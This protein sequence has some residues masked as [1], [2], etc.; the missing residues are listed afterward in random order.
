MAVGLYSKSY[1]E[2]Y[3]E[4]PWCRIG[5]YIVGIVTGYLLAAQRD[6]I[7]LNWSIATIG[8]LA[9]TAVALAVIFGLHKDLENAGEHAMS[10]AEAAFYNALA[11]T[12]WAV[13]ICWV[14]VACATGWGGFVNSF[15]SWS[16]FVVLGRLSYL[17]YLIHVAVIDVYFGNQ[18]TLLYFT[19]LHFAMCFVGI[20]VV[21]YMFSFVLMLA[22]ESPMIGLEKVVLHQRTKI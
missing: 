21:T 7:K 2:N 5:P 1:F 12:A 17:A 4:A 19:S 15:L 20:I 13:S 3:Y 8:W 22:L 9:A 16:P 10:V 18:R 11:S 6:R 14:I